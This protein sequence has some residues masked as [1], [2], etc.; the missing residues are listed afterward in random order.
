MKIGI[1]AMLSEKT[2]DPVSAASLGGVRG[3]RGAP[4]DFVPDP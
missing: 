1:F 4:V 3:S 2:I